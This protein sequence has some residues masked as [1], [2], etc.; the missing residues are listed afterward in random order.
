MNR[1]GYF[2]WGTVLVGFLVVMAVCV[3]A[4]GLVYSSTRARSFHSRPLV[5]IH[6]PVNRDQVLVGERVVTHATARSDNGV[7][8]L[9]LW[10][11]DALVAARDAPE[12]SSPSN[13]TLSTSWVPHVTGNHVL[14]VRA[15]STDGTEGQAVVMVD[16]IESGEGKMGRHIV[17]DGETLESIAEEYGTTPA[18]L[19]DLNPSFGPGGPRPGDE[20][21]V[22]DTEPLVD[23]DE[24]L[25]EGGEAP[26]AEDNPPGSL[27]IFELLF[28]ISPFGEEPEQ[29]SLRLEIP[30]LRTWDAH[31][32][33]HCYVGLAGNPP[34]WYPDRDNNQSTDESFL[35]QDHGWW[36]TAP[37][38]EGSSSPVIT[39]PSDQPLPVSVTCVGVVGGVE[40]LELGRVE[41]TIPP[42]DWDGIAY[43]VE[44][45]GS[46]GHY[47]FAYRITRL[48][49]AP[50]GIPMFLEPDMTPPFDARLDDRRISLRWE[51]TPRE[52]EA[53]IDGFRIYLNGNL[54]WVEPSDSRESGLPYEWFNPPCGT[55]YSYSVTAFRIGFPDGPESFPSYAFLE[56]PLENC[57]REMQIIFLT[58]ETF[59]LGGDGRYE[60]RHGDVG[61]AYGYF[62]A[63]E[64][65][66]TFDGGDLGPGLDMPNGLR[67]NTT[68][69]LGEMSADRTWRFS[70][71]N[72]TIVDVPP[73]GTFEF[74][75]H[76][77]DEDSGRCRDSDDPGCHDLIC[78]GISPIHEDRYGEFDRTH[79]GSLTA[80]N[81]RCRL[82]Y[83]WGPAFGS[84]VGTGVEGW[85]PLPWINLEDFVVE[86]TT[87]RVQIHVRNTGTA[88]WPWRDLTIELQTRSGES[89]G[90]Y[91]WQDF[92]LE[93][94][95]ETVLEHPD[96]MLSAPF[97]ACVVIDPYDE[98]PEEFERSG[99]LFHNPICQRLPDLTITD[100]RFD[101]L[102]GGRVR[103]TV[104]NVGDAALEN[105]TVSFQSLLA[106]GSPA[107]LNRSWPSIG[108]EPRQM[109]TFEL[110]GVTESVRNLLV[111]GYSITV[112]PD[113]LIAE[114]NL[115]NNTYTVR[116]V[117]N[118]VIR[119]CETVVPH[120][121]G[122]GH[123]VRMDM[124][125]SAVSGE[126]ER[127]LLTQRIEDYF[128]YIYIDD[129]DTHYVVGDR[130]PGLNCRTIGDFEIFG[131]EQLR[132]T[133]AGQYQS[134]DSGGWD[135]LGA[136]TGTFAPQNHWEADV[137]PICSGYDYTLFDAHT[138]WHDFVVH[139]DLGMLAPPPWTAIFHLCLE[140]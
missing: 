87:G 59:D 24:P 47:Y 112:N 64:K 42:E 116:G 55:R 109:R 113:G 89:I 16:A 75:F 53:P 34:Q 103:V 135:N 91:T 131:D 114:S 19:D 2:R 46:E 40:A 104:Q 58:L 44:V 110:T 32:G 80:E 85:E 3:L 129:Y 73:D 45:A 117:S 1:S 69:N 137:S 123:T 83:Q 18:V 66:I 95:Q 68:Y 125:V 43:D 121:Y 50:R 39:W 133:I 6:N 13:L 106:D 108:L 130:V 14:V 12:D 15:L 27:G 107:Y 134:G 84:P 21:V 52:D 17:E 140:D 99:A 31:D 86:E 139:P 5:L 65:Q 127:S 115:R 120:Y 92:V 119:W 61:P 33:L 97:D 72:S 118:M 28:G 67:H 26:G 38:L 77:M 48:D 51:Y 101:S 71:M 41:L 54:Q 76:I 124:T 90:I 94:G 11:G 9:E 8:R 88:T 96:M 132:V 49:D 22:P 79:E 105:R 74:G 37:D 78:E 29:V 93:T 98:M 20:L 70:G 57:N 136:G 128:S 4:A 122:W 7:L 23:E 82:T 25:V 56:T 100:V 111:N 62:F 126:S 60:D 81:G 138:G 63:N 102:G 36:R 35:P 10:V 30:K